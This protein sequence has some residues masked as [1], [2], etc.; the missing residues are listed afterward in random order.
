MK[1]SLRR[2]SAVV[3]LVVMLCASTFAG[4]LPFPVKDDPLP[5]P[6]SQSI[7]VTGDGTDTPVNGSGV[8]QM[9]DETTT[10]PVAEIVLTIMQS[11]L[12]LI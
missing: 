3:I 2:W 8:N 11:V 10:D 12:P 4:Q 9:P 6:P 1:N 5:P 7:T